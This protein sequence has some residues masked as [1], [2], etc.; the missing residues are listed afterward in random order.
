MYKFRFTTNDLINFLKINGIKKDSNIF[1]HS[2]WQE[3]YNYK[4]SVNELLQALIEEFGI[5][6][7]VAMPSY[8]PYRAGIN[9]KIIAKI[10]TDE[11]L[12]LI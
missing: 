11:I 2:S 4:G 8:F 3:F 7:T 5:K 10:L 6:G 12:S 9:K 1:I